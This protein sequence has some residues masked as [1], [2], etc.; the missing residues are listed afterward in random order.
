MIGAIFEVPFL[1]AAM[2]YERPYYEDTHT[3]PQLFYVIFGAKDRSLNVSRDRHHVDEVPEGV[4]YLL[5]RRARHE[6][7]MASLI[8]DNLG[9]VL[10][11]E[12]PELYEAVRHTETWAVV[13]GEAARDQD[14]H[15]LR[16][17]IGLVE[18]AA[19]EGAVAVLDLQTV[20]L[21][22]P[23]EWHD[24]IFGRDF[25]PF[26]H[27]T[28]LASRM[29]TGALWLH[30]RGMRKFGRPDVSLADVPPADVE[31]A[32]QLIN[33]MIY[34]GA[35]GTFF[36]QPVRLHPRPGVTCGLDPVLVND[37]NNPDFNNAFYRLSWPDCKAV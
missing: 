22:T 9:T 3:R 8:G 33:Q 36:S 25:D 5:Y 35:L 34:Y 4:S 10:A 20:T 24:K 23:Q 18:A 17:A 14:L 28:I 2:E 1:E 7:T 16:N 31:T 27:V 30:T 19:E 6:G 29:G 37:M 13:R 21:Y 32:V 11:R 26:V 12:R 15:Y